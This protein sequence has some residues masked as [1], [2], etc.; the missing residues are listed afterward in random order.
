MTLFTNVAQPDQTTTTARGVSRGT[1][2]SLNTTPAARSA[3][4]H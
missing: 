2:N 1:H 4:T 3:Q